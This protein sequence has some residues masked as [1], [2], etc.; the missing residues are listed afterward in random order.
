[1]RLLERRTILKGGAAATAALCLPGELGAS[2]RRAGVFVVDRRFAVSEAIAR[3]RRGRGALVV[4]PR[5]ED[6]GVSW[7]GRI[8]AWLG[9]NEASVEGVT[10]WSGFIICQTF[11]RSFGLRL[12]GAPQPAAS[13]AEHGLHRWLLVRA[14]TVAS[15]G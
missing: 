11:A 15:S 14:G 4:D 6:L 7:R 9:Q 2:G 13:A 3:D 12:A 1:M 10:L 5:E 8:P